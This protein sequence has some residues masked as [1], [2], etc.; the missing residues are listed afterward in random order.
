M[1]F[2]FFLIGFLVIVGAALY[3]FRRVVGLVSTLVV[4]GFLL[5]VGS[6]FGVWTDRLPFTTPPWLDGFLSVLEFP[7]VV[8]FTL[9]MNFLDFL[10]MATGR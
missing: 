2:L 10:Q 7:F 1:T 3:V 9:F 8:V 4:L 6:Y 5:V